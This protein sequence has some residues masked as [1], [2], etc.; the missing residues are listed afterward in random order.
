MKAWVLDQ[1]PGGGA[2]L[3]ALADHVVEHFALPAP[4][5]LPLPHS[6]PGKAFVISGV[7][8]SLYRHEAEDIIR[9][10]GGRVTGSV[11]G[12]TAFLLAGSNCGRSKYRAVRLAG[13]QWG[14]GT[15][16]GRRWEVEVRGLWREGQGRC[17]GGE[18]KG[19][20][21]AGLKI[22]CWEEQDTRVA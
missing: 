16:P 22:R 10:H 2:L 20:R 19:A 4:V 1:Q 7:L 14:L 3:C 6:P 9:R 21:D 8:D 18:G 5:L 11:S 15:G 17:E 12:K 13:G